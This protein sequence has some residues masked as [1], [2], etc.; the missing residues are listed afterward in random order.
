MW[1]PFASL[2]GNTWHSKFPIWFI[3]SLLLQIFFLP[4]LSPH[5]YLQLLIVLDL[6]KNVFLLLL[7][8]EKFSHVYFLALSVTF[9]MYPSSKLL[10][11]IPHFYSYVFIDNIPTWFFLKNLFHSTQNFIISLSTSVM[12]IWTSWSVCYNCFVSEGVYC[13]LLLSFWSTVALPCC[14]SFCCIQGSNLNAHEQRNG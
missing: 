11:L 1:N 9:W 7:L 4:I 2:L 8:S 14:V 6:K 3:S 10:C 5:S 12:T 13:S